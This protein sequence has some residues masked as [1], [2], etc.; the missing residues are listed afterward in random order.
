[1]V[2]GD[3]SLR[4]SSKQAQDLLAITNGAARQL[5]DDERVRQNLLVV[6]KGLQPWVPDAEMVNPH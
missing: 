1:M 2:F 4:Q 3:A 5:T 6:K